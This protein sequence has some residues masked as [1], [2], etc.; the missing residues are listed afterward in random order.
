M[1]L[2]W[3]QVGLGRQILSAGKLALLNQESRC[4]TGSVTA[5]F[6]LSGSCYL[7]LKAKTQWLV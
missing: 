7:T 4:G 3:R 5:S 2:S 6:N 1:L